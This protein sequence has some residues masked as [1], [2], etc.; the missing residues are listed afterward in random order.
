M[1]KAKSRTT[2]TTGRTARPRLLSVKEAR[3]RVARQQR[4]AVVSR[5]DG[6]VLAVSTS[7][8]AARFNRSLHAVP[9]Y[10]DRVELRV[11]GVRA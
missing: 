3:R 11:L 9:T 1:A 2:S 4:W 7:R 10:V 5:V 6:E 8:A